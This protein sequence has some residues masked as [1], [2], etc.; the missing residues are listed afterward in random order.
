M[1]GL[2]DKRRY[3]SY[4]R[5]A[6]QKNSLIWAFFNVQ[7]LVTQTWQNQ[8]GQVL[9]VF[10]LMII[11]ATCNVLHL[12]NRNSGQQT[13]WQDFL[14]CCRLTRTGMDWS[15]SPLLKVQYLSKCRINLHN[16]SITLSMC[17]YSNTRCLGCVMIRPLTT[18]KLNFPYIL[19]LCTT[20]FR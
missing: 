8:L 16:K 14:T 7:I 5:L 9:L 1:S 6:F 10:W 11:Y 12:I 13:A 20:N 3:N 19:S 15:S 17:S 2:Y 4:L 18:V